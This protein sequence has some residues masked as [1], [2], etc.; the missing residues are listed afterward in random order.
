MTL[1]CPLTFPACKVRTPP[2]PGGTPV[3]VE[4]D[5]HRDLPFPPVTEPRSGVCFPERSSV[6]GR[7]RAPGAA[8]TRHGKAPPLSR[9]PRDP[10]L[11]PAARARPFP[12]VPTGVSR[13]TAPW[14]A[15]SP[16]LSSSG[17]NVLSTQNVGCRGHG[18]LP[19]CAEGAF[20]PCTADV[21]HR[22]WGAD[23]DEALTYG[24]VP[25]APV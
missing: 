16:F 13:A 6:V 22:S 4:D 14:G 9:H 15:Q 5:G 19:R 2:E 8:R 20:D 3:S 12:R 24:L 23:G 17:V 1:V 11:S 21:D 18:A 10:C 7:L 25:A